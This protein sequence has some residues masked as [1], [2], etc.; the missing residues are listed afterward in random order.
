MKKL[1]RLLLR[2][3]AQGIN[4]V[5]RPVWSEWPFFLAM[6][7]LLAPAT[8]EKLNL[9][10]C[11][12]DFS[13]IGVYYWQKT[14]TFLGIAFLVSY[15]LTALIHYLHWN[16]KGKMLLY[17][18]AMANYVMY[19]FI[20]CNFH[21]RISPE[22]A[23]IMSET[24]PGESQEFLDTYL[25]AG[26]SLVAYAAPLLA[27]A[28]I[29]LVELLR[30]RWKH[31]RGSEWLKTV[32]SLLVLGGVSYGFAGL[33]VPLGILQ[34]KTL[35]E[36]E[37]SDNFMSNW[38]ADECTNY[39]YT[40]KTLS[41]S[42]QEIGKVVEKTTKV[43]DN[44]ESKISDPQD[45]LN[46]IIVI[47][48]SYNKHH[49]GIYG[50]TLNTTPN[51]KQ[52]KKRG[53]LVVFNDVI[54]PYNTTS[55]TL[56]NVLSC[57]SMAQEESWWNHPLFPALFKTAGY[58]VMLWDNQT[59]FSRNSTFSFSLNSV[60]YNSDIV[61]H[62]YDLLNEK[63]FPYDTMLV[64]DFCNKWTTQLKGT[65]RMGIIH[66][67]GQHINYSRRYPQGSRYDKFTASDIKRNDPYLTEGMK[68]TIAEY[69]NATLYN[70]EVLRQ[71]FSFFRNSNTVIIYFSDHGEEVY[72]YRNYMGRDHNVKKSANLLH[73]QNEIPFMV[74]MSPAFQRNYPV[75]VSRIRNAVDNPFTN[76]D[77]S[78]MLFDLGH[79]KT[80]YY[81][82]E[83]NPLSTQFIPG[84]RIVYDK[85]D[86]DELIKDLDRQQPQNWQK[87]GK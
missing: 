43:K 80:P 36:L 7:F 82:A 5:G 87:S 46:V 37:R 86:Y 58:G 39:L 10:I 47:G 78:N 28:G 74:W 81:K 55:I 54:S 31:V 9:L 62:S 30:A 2:R 14:F 57:N 72:D 69:D 24:T 59:N 83:R 71:I 65:H 44:G 3:A 56:K 8:F 21:T 13:Y 11:Q 1:T 84:K 53:N 23:V 19:R 48:E 12:W 25:L 75:T 50:Y 15:T 60:M 76:D 16:R 33:A 26:N 66:L 77:L 18:L 51:L 45:S 52:E 34:C 61:A 32:G 68:Q 64:D 35:I 20:F 70:D 22:L 73:Q 67:M 85:Y 63:S 4:L 40:A 6:I 49:A 38:G 41:L 79:I 17:S 42:T 27:T 29:L